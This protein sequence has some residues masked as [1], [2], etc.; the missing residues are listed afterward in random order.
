MSDH[1]KHIAALE[2]LIDFG[3]CRGADMLNTLLKS[4]VRVEVPSLKIID[5]QDL[6]VEVEILGVEILAAVHMG[7]EGSLTG[8]S[9][10]VFRRNCALRLVERLAGDDL[11]SGDFDFVSTSVLTEI[12]NIV[13]NGV[14]GSISNELKLSLDFVVPTFFQGGAGELIQVG[15]AGVE[16]PG[17]FAKTRFIVEELREDGNIILFLERDSYN[18]LIS[19]IEERQA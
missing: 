5:T 13:L 10:L 15:C 17:L 2:R 9:G 11:G 14:M 1:G 3:A 18:T 16:R 19:T 7:F 8:H 12:G 6:D 4:S